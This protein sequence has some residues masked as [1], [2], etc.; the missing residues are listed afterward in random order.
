M[1]AVHR[2]GFD[3]RRVSLRV[4]ERWAL[5]DAEREALHTWAHE[6]GWGLV[7]LATCHRMEVYVEG[8]TAAAADALSW[9]AAHRPDLDA[10]DLET[11]S[12]ADA[13]QHLF[14]VAAG[15][16]SAVLGEAQ[17]LGQVRRARADAERAGA[18][19]PLLREAFGAAVGV[20]RSVRA[21][22][23]I[24][25]GV[26]STASAA[27][28]LASR[29]VGGLGGRSVVVIGGGEIGRLLLKH[30]AGTAPAQLSLVSRHARIPGVACHPPEALSALLASADVVFTGTDR[31]AVRAADLAA[32]AGR[33]LTLV[34][35]GVPRNV[36]PEVAHL[37]G[38]TLHDVDALRDVVGAG[39]AERRAA[40]PEAEQMVQAALERFAGTK[41]RV[42]RERLVADMR[43]RAE[44]TRREAVAYVCGRCPDRTC[45]SDPAAAAP[46]P[47]PCSDPDRL[48]RTVATR[49]LHDLT[50]GLRQEAGLDEAALR[51]LFAL[52][53]PEAR[54]G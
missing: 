4:R 27:V 14:R 10:A 6:R 25:R 7:A 32:R 26:A 30:V 35:L 29:A 54:H 46:G 52:P 9:L 2:I 36:D 12:D 39:L 33:P 53:D 19:T 43:R 23:A 16:E 41:A 13:L 34:D 17:I 1:T 31:V 37:P 20:G 11:T 48:T 40:V 50:R 49:L 24:G 28:G 44:R 3:G 51:R 18:L 5:T 15:L 45:V 8:P 42:G 47:G 38:V 22:T 21:Q